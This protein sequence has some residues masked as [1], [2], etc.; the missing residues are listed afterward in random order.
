MQELQL[1]PF[2]YKEPLTTVALDAA[3]VNASN[4]CF[5]MAEEGTDLQ[6]PPSRTPPFAK[7]DRLHVPY[8]RRQK[9]DERCLK[10]IWL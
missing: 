7:K 10:C 3:V 2:T 9:L 6:A 8:T 5:R 4:S 1:C